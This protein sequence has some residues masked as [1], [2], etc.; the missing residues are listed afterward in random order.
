MSSIYSF[1]A[2]RTYVNE[3][4]QFDL[5]I[6]SFKTGKIIYEIRNAGSICFHNG[7]TKLE[8]NY[9]STNPIKKTSISGDPRPTR[10]EIYAYFESE[11]GQ[12]KSY[13]IKLQ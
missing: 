12:E 11:V 2:S 1:R 7:Q 8:H 5:E 6:G 13:P 9:S 4:Q 10:V 3:N